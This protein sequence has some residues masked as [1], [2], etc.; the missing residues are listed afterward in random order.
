VDVVV[1]AAMVGKIAPGQP[2]RVVAAVGGS[3][4]SAKVAMVDR[5]IDA[6][7]GTFVVRLD[8]PN[9][10]LKVPVGSMCTAEFG[11]A[12]VAAAGP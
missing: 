4:F 7:S 1:P 11:A 5:V 8:L 3:R 2:A 12:A 10:Q 6:A 9:P